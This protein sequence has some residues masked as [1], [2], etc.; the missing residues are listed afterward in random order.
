V[1]HYRLKTLPCVIA[2]LVMQAELWGWRVPRPS[3]PALATLWR[4]RDATV[5]SS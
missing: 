5:T 3:L 2:W 1:M 4:A